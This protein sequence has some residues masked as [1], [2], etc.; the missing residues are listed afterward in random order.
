MMSLRKIKTF[1]KMG[2][3]EKRMSLE[4]FVLSGLVRMMLL[5]V[6]FK[7]IRNYLGEYNAYV[8]REIDED[9]CSIVRQVGWFVTTISRYTPWESKCLVQAMVAQ[10]LLKKRKIG[11]TLYL[12]VAKENKQ[13][14]KAH[15]WLKCGNIIVA[16]RAAMNDYKEVARFDN[17]KQIK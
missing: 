13:N 8:P 10:R 14:I 17:Y 2:L 16:G 4:I 11:T 7:Y 3:T 6:P 1:L 9:Q 12:G 5:I 15:A